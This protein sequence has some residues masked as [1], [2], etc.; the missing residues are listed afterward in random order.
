MKKT[1]ALLV[2]SLLFLSGAGMVFS[3]NAEMIRHENLVFGYSLALPSFFAHKSNDYRKVLL[4]TYEHDTERY[5]EFERWESEDGSYAFEVMVKL[6]T[7]DSFAMEVEKYADYLST[8]KSESIIHPRFAFNK[9]EILTFEP[10]K[11]LLNAV[12]YEEVSEEKG[13][14]VTVC[15]FYLDHYAQEDLE[16]IFRLITYNKSVSESRKILLDVAKTI[17]IQPLTIQDR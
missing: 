15:D 11:M 7:W 3:S 16:Y 2:A 8:L 9:T 13:K 4:E 14:E 12:C 10:G 6:Q 1:M 17:H 5:F